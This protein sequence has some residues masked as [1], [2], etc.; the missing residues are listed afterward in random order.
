[1]SVNMSS[2]EDA[3]F[4]FENSP[5]RVVAVRNSP[6]IELV[7]IEVGP[8]EEGN[9]YSIKFWVARQLE[10]AG[11]V[12]FPEDETLDVARLLRIQWTERIQSV[13]QVSSL[14]EMFYPRLRYLLDELKAS[15]RST[16]EK[17]KEYEKVKWLSQDI[18]TCRLKK[19]ISLASA[20]DHVDQVLR[21]LTVE[22]RKLY[23]DLTRIISEWKAKILQ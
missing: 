16:V 7:G 19:I 2:I 12:R 1:M 18:A 17:M 10:K 8:F 3:D 5:M 20:S 14:P 4:V 6:K 21:N 13:S 11:A 22:E 23:E 15:S 9:E